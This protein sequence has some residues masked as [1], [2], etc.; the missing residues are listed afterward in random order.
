MRLLHTSD[1]HLGKGLG[2]F[3]LEEA[4]RKY[5]DQ[6]DEIVTDQDVDALLIS[7]DIFD[8]QLPSL[9]ALA[10]FENALERLSAKTTVIITSGNHDGARRLG[11]SR[12]LLEK[13]NIYIRTSIDDI[14]RPVLLEK[15][16]VKTSIYGIPF[17]EPFTTAAKLL[18]T[19]NETTRSDRSHKNVLTA[20]IERV[21]NHHA[22]NPADRTVVMSHAWFAGADGDGSEIDV[23]VGGL[24]NTPTSVLSKFTYAALGHIHKPNV[25][26]NHIRYCGSALQYSF[27]NRDIPKVSFVVDLSE[28]KPKVTPI[29][30]YIHRKMH[31]IEDSFEKLM[32]SRE[33][34]EHRNSYLKIR[35]LD[36]PP[37]QAINQLRERFP[38]IAD[39]SIAGVGGVAPVWEKMQGMTEEEICCDFIEF[40]R[41]TPPNQLEETFFANAIAHA[42]RGTIGRE[43]DIANSIELL[44]E[45]Q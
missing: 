10:I 29:D 11:F 28:N 21:H 7:G 6:V 33:Y 2:P 25:I 42:R 30:N 18:E 44:S 24:E 16:G 8:K 3:D 4:Q 27:A 34:E 23:K 5:V 26:D 9:G 35:A 15:N 31:V 39:F 19:G 38:Y 36:A 1:W 13:S 12:S 20:A 45:P 14:N 32:N 41:G 43:Q 37:P 40:S 22:A 17:L